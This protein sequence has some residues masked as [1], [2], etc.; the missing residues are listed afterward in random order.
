MTE[1]QATANSAAERSAATV[2]PF[3]GVANGHA[4]PTAVAPRLLEVEHLEVSF[5]VGH[6]VVRAVNDVSF[7]IARGRTLGIIGESGSG[8]SVTARSIMGLLRAKRVHVGGSIR[9]EGAELIGLSD[10]KLSE[11][12]GNEI[13]LVPQ[14]PTRSLN[15]TLQIGKQIVEAIRLHEPVSRE[16]AKQRAIELLGRVRLPSPKQ[17]FFEYPHQ[18]SGG[19]RQRAVIAMALSC[20]PSLLIADEATTAL[21]VTTQAQIMDLLMDLQVETNMAMLVIS[22]DIAI[23]AAYTDEVAVMYAGRIVEHAPT[24]LLFEKVQM[25]Y[26]QALLEAV[27]DIERAPHEHLRVVPGVPPDPTHPII[28]CAFA[29]RCPLVEDICRS[30]IPPLIEHEPSHA[31]ACFFAGATG[32]DR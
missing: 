2:D 24:D 11:Y 23:A 8:K 21:D 12:R 27:P 16:V 1:L 13:A 9:F 3:A 22:H 18:L 26:T 10:R 32:A 17:R 5:E 7:G 14:D 28:G 20:S 30:E 15:P 25:P 29:K 4:A 31:W 6:T 19:M